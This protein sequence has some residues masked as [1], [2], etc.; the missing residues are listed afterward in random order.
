ML[1]VVLYQ[2]AALVDALD[3]LV[4]GGAELERAHHRTQGAIPGEG[5]GVKGQI[6][7]RGLWSALIRG[8][9]FQRGRG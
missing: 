5:G 2:V 4:G 8:A 6:Q 7:L 3:V 9:V 1:G